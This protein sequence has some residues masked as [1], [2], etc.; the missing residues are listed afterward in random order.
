M[1]CGSRQAA[2]VCQRQAAVDLDGVVVGDARR[3]RAAL[4]SGRG[5]PR[6]RSRRRAAQ[7]RA[8][9]CGS[10][11]VDGDL[12]RRGLGDGHRAP[13]RVVAVGVQVHHQ[14]HLGAVV[15]DLAVDVQHE[16]GHRRSSAYGP[17]AG[18]HGRASPSAPSA[19]HA[20]DPPVVVVV[21]EREHAR[22]RRAASRSC[23]SRRRRRRSGW[24]PAR[25][26]RGRCARAA[27]RS[28]SAAPATARV[29]VEVHHRR[30]RRPRP[31]ATARRRGGGC[32]TCPRPA[33]IAA[34]RRSAC[35]GAA[36]GCS[37]HWKP[38]WSSELRASNRSPC[39]RRYGANEDRN[40][41]ASG[42]NLCS[43]ADDEPGPTGRL[44]ALLSLLQ[45]RPQLDRTRA[46]RP[47]RRHGAHRAP[48]RRAA[49][50]A[51][52]PG[53]RR[54]RRRRRLPARR[55]RSGDAAADA[56]P[57][58]GASPSPCRLRSTADR[59]DRRRR[60]GGDP[61]ARQARAAA[62]ADAAPPGRRD[63]H[64]DGAPRRQLVARSTPS[65]LVTLTRA[66]RDGERLR[67]RYRD[68]RGRETERRSTRTASSRR[69]RR[70]YLVAHD[71]RPRRLA[72]VPRR[73]L[74]RRR[75]DRPPR[76]ASRTRPI[77]WRSCRRRSRR[78]R[79]ATRPAS[80]CR[81]DRRR[82]TRSCR[83]PS[84][85]A[86]GDRRPSRTM[87]TTGGDDLDVLVFHLARARRRLRRPR[88]G[89]RCGHDIGGRR[90]PPH[91]RAPLR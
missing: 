19:A 57:R 4:G 60:R 64:D 36:A 78:R 51:R 34:A 12:D 33:P 9:A 41:P 30:R 80:S 62:A 21:H 91:G 14:R 32:S 74:A 56:R 66:C 71:R 70:W 59:L 54:H 29:D 35:R 75:G 11:A 89:R 47:A 25:R 67:V 28:S 82:A 58:R 73:P 44:L 85:V 65:V 13:R 61:G 53:A 22:R 88:A 27:R 2:A 55:R 16:G 5:G 26:R 50:P 45:G 76:R 3:R 84:G 63:R 81:A 43:M 24:T 69:P 79:T 39:A 86:R 46:R 10:A 49:A 1:P 77:R 6:A 40:G 23:R 42:M 15:Q 90:R 87:L 52:L 18:P 83:R 72:H 68:P 20:G 7:N 8:R 48:R 17:S 37:S 31:S 38:S